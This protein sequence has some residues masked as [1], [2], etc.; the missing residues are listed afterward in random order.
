MT[1]ISSLQ[2]SGYV[3]TYSAVAGRSHAQLEEVL[4]FASGTLSNGFRVY[5]LSEPIVPTDFVW[6][7]R[8]RYSDG[9][10]LDPSIGEYV[11][12]V[13]ELRAHL[14]KNL[15]YD[16]GLVDRELAS[17]QVAQV[18]KLN[19]RSGPGRIVKIL[20]TAQ[21]RSFPDSPVRNIPQWRLTNKKLFV[22]VGTA[23]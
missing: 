9:W 3:T 15:G 17:F 20:P 7:D 18:N 19:I 22:F 10:H 2:L 12:R 11:Q 1:S 23:V 13:D 21:S 8:T 16:E 6:K 5:Q 4:G 14:G